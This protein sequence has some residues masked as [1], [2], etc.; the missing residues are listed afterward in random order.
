ML[1]VTCVI[2]HPLFWFIFVGGSKSKQIKH[3]Y[4][5]YGDP[6]ILKCLNNT[7]ASAWDGPSLKSSNMYNETPYADKNHIVQHLPNAKNLMVVGDINVGEYNLKIINLT[8]KE[9]GYY[10]CNGHIGITPFEKRFLLK[11]KGKQF[12]FPEFS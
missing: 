2:H 10:K 11:I 4:A 12:R 7:N 5:R 1:T 9:E 8:R 3:V 6:V